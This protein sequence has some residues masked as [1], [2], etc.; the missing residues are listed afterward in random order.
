MADT[1]GDHPHEDFALHRLAEHQLLE[2][3]RPTGRRKTSPRVVVATQRILPSRA[4]RR[5]DVPRGWRFGCRLGSWD[6]RATGADAGTP[7][8]WQDPC[9]NG[10]VITVPCGTQTKPR[11]TLCPARPQWEASLDMRQFRTMW[12]AVIGGL[13]LIAL[14]VSVAFGAKPID[15]EPTA[16]S[17]S[18]RSGMT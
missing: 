4:R 12:L 6:I 16:A 15:T 5:E 1:G 13:L 9:E 11:R 10:R 7:R 14:S 18:R 3:Q 17:K 8:N 2:V